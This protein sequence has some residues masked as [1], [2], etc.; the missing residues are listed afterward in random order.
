MTILTLSSIVAL[1]FL[2][3]MF[4]NPFSNKLENFVEEHI[5]DNKHG[6]I[7]SLFDKEN[8]YF[9]EYPFGISGV[10]CNNNIYVF[11][12]TPITKCAPSAH[13]GAVFQVT[14]EGFVSKCFITE[15][16]VREIFK[17]VPIKYFTSGDQLKNTK[18]FARAQEVIETVLKITNNI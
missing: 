12:K 7:T 10:I 17:N 18:F 2:I 15:F 6:I 1:C 8:V 16:L 14:K 9:Y 4:G 3:V 11:D 5:G 13:Y